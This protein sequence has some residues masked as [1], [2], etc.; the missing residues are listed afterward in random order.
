MVKYLPFKAD[1]KILARKVHQSMSS[2]KNPFTLGGWRRKLAAFSILAL[3]T[4]WPMLAMAGPDANGCLNSPQDVVEAGLGNV[5]VYRAD[6]GQWVGDPFDHQVAGSGALEVLFN[7][8][9]YEDTGQ[10]RIL[11]SSCQPSGAANPSTINEYEV[12]E[13]ANNLP[14][15]MFSMGRLVTDNVDELLF[16]ASSA[17]YKWSVQAGG[18]K[19]VATV[20]GPSG[21]YRSITSI[22]VTN[23]LIETT[24]D[25]G[26]QGCRHDEIQVNGWGDFTGWNQHAYEWTHADH[27][28][29]DQGVGYRCP[30][31]GRKLMGFGNPFYMS[32]YPHWE[33]HQHMKGMV[34]EYDGP[35]EGAW[36][37]WTNQLFVPDSNIAGPASLIGLTPR[38]FVVLDDGK[39]LVTAYGSNGGTYFPI[40]ESR[41][42]D[43]A[44]PPNADRRAPQK[45]G[46]W[47]LAKHPDSG[48]FTIMGGEQRVWDPY[49]EGGPFNNYIF[50]L[51]DKKP[52][53][54]L[55]S[56]PTGFWQ[57]RV[58]KNINGQYQEVDEMN[59][60]YVGAAVNPD[61]KRPIIAS[62]LTNGL[63][64]YEA[65]IDPNDGRSIQ[66][67]EV[68]WV[69]TSGHHSVVGQTYTDGAYFAHGRHDNQG[70]GGM[71]FAVKAKK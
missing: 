34:M 15:D 69:N 54:S 11:G 67:Y 71:L 58:F 27:D 57:A 68:G 26:G 53:Y 40:L 51:G 52:W 41:T 39:V 46:Y 17:V 19:L 49:I 25:S 7:G 47:E 36:D 3:I 21:N 13:V 44:T 64:F 48:Q 62:G 24:A 4:A 42:W 65:R 32:D 2:R 33:E 37:T 35:H 12:L 59:G 63:A 61:T 43:Q 16:G 23:N 30:R 5:E 50:L 9:W 38:S 28:M 22:F 70:G 55:R 1:F 8:T 18:T 31:T 6:L 20:R 10:H 60:A 29:Q 66:L 45:Q 56:D 14:K